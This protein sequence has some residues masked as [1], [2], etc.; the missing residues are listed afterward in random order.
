MTKKI[1]IV[2]ASHGGHQ[3]IIESLNRYEDVDVTLF[4]AGD[5]I[6]FM[7]CGMQLYLENKVTDVDDVRNFSEDTFKEKNVHV[8]SN[9]LVTK[10]N[11]D[12]KTVTVENDGKS[13]D[14]SYDKLILSS[15]VTPNTLPVPGADLDNVFL[16]RGKD[17]ATKIKSQL[18]DES[19]KNVTI[20]GAGYIGIEAAEVSKKY[21]KNV[22]II[23]H[24]EHVLGTYLDYELSD[25]IKDEL[26][27]NGINLELSANVE[28]FN[29]NGSV[30]S[31]KISDKEIPSDLV[32]QAAGIKPNTEWLKGII[33]LDNHGFIETD[34]Y[35]RTNVPDVYAVGDATLV[36][37]IPAQ[38][39][40]PIALATVARRQARYV[41]KH[42]FE[43]LP[44][45]SFKGVNGSSALSVFDYHFATTGI[46]EISANKINQKI[47]SNF[48]KGKLRPS[49]VAESEN[50]QEVYVE[51]NYLPQTH[52][53]VGGTV[54]SKGDVTAHGNTLS[55]AISNKMTL[56][57]LADTDFFFQPG[58][59]RQ[60]S[61]LNLAAQ[62]ALG[63]YKF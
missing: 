62:N 18:E 42:L 50:N 44:T 43:K 34:E 37:S 54:L 23:D 24:N 10:I 39:K 58:F 19:I 5:F 16:M 29:G 56:E 49:Y 31:V 46:N 20:I 3:A 30:E 59:D 6:S 26:I 2:G 4:E 51:L 1:V 13:K 11:S 21:G 27:S 52:Q 36:Y 48:Y 14:V 15:G 7:S 57:D 38:E 12:Q 53:I 63:E 22:T 9:H 47:N 41:V 40:M 55:L 61:L 8:L 35:L 60:W 32:I 28:A 17:W 45:E 33:N 25:L